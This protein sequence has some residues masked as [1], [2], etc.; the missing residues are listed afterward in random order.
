MNKNL[1][2]EKS[3]KPQFLK[4]LRILLLIIVSISLLIEIYMFLTNPG[5]SSNAISPGM[6]TLID[7]MPLIE[8]G[9]SALISLICLGVA[10]ISLK[11]DEPKFAIFFIV[12]AIALPLLVWYLNINFPQTYFASGTN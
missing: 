3:E 1:I 8:L 10:V 6:Q 9:M 2:N 5:T 12:A 11:N 7:N 4:G